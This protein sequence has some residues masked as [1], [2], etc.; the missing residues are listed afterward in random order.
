M[1]GLAPY[2]VSNEVTVHVDIHEYDTKI[3][4]NINTYL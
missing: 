3:T 2:Y 4:E 1:P